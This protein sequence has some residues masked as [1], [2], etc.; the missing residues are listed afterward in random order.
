MYKYPKSMFFQPKTMHLSLLT[1]VFACVCVFVVIITDTL[2]DTVIPT[3]PSVP[4]IYDLDMMQDQGD[5][6]DGI[7]SAT[8]SPAD[9]NMR[10]GQ[11]E[12]S[13]HNIETMLDMLK[14]Q[15]HWKRIAK[16]DA[17]VNNELKL[18]LLN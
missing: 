18:K 15:V 13:V 7:V 2:Q 6:G 9:S 11:L 5:R 1:C 8:R 3:S 12:N 17:G 14:K 4:A 16:R 10:L